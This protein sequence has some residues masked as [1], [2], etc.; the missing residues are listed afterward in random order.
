[1]IAYV[2]SQRIREIGIRTALGAQPAGLVKMFVRHGLWLAGTGAAFGLVAAAGLTRLMST[3]LFGVTALDPVTYIAVSARLLR[4]GVLASYLPAR[5]ALA[6]DPT[7]A[8]R[9]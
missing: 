3:L 4:A 5:R 2:V 9:A 6:V 1:V 8:L 7:Q